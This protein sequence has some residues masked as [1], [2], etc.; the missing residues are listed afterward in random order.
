MAAS[1]GPSRVAAILGGFFPTEKP[2]LCA[3]LRVYFD[4]S[5]SHASSE[6]AVVA[7]YLAHIDQWERLEADWNE[8]LR[9]EGVKEIKGYRRLH[10]KELTSGTGGFEGW[11]NPR[12]A[13]LLER[14]GTLIN[15]RV[16]RLIGVGVSTHSFRE[17]MTILNAYGF[18]A[19][20]IPK[21]PLSLCLI[22]SMYAIEGWCHRNRVEGE[23][24]AF[25]FEE[26]DENQKEVQKFMNDLADDP[27]LRVRS[28]YAGWGFGGKRLVPLQAADWIAYELYLHG[29]R[30]VLP[31]F[32]LG[33]QKN[34]RPTRRS[35]KLL[36]RCADRS[37]RYG[38]TRDQI[39]GTARIVYE[40]GQKESRPG[41]TER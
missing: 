24:V 2:G 23:Q 28:R 33:D 18:P 13:R 35:L 40:W 4:S 19:L 14:L 25:Y 30:V 5:G 39:L 9:Q 10:M 8:V 1:V 38:V 31:K 17:A 20:A 11:D 29:V 6:M 16:S 37:I 27:E 3:V 26:G 34:Q 36:R 15:V 12:R 41:Q 21:S 22:Q 7:G 32:G